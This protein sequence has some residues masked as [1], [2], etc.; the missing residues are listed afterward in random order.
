MRG[1]RL[2]R[3]TVSFP[4][5][6]L[7]PPPKLL[8]ISYCQSNGGLRRRRQRSP[9]PP[10]AGKVRDLPKS[11]MSLGCSPS[12]KLTFAFAGEFHT[13]AL[14]RKEEEEEGGGGEGK[15]GFAVYTKATEQTSDLRRRGANLERESEIG[16]GGAGQGGA[17]SIFVSH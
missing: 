2:G 9:S 7:L 16:V 1:D 12:S 17:S 4:P 8:L 13:G 3:T 14:Q 11:G 15:E 10:G 5:P 6:I